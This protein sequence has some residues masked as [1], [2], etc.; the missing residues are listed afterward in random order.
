MSN[1]QEVLEE[2]IE[3]REYE[4][5]LVSI[6][7]D[8]EQD[9]TKGLRRIT[10]WGQWKSDTASAERSAERAWDAKAGRLKRQ[11]EKKGYKV[12]LAY[13]G[14]STISNDDNTKFRSK[15]RGDVSWSK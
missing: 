1:Q 7:A 13:G 11:L 15:S 14:N 3:Q 12:S 6:L 8:L 9:S 5:D 4:E 10:A 2:H